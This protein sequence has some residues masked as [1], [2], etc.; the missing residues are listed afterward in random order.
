VIVYNCKRQRTHLQNI[1]KPKIRGE[2]K[3]KNL[4]KKT[5]ALLITLS[6]V[7][8]V[9]TF[10]YWASNVEGTSE[11]ATGTLEVGS[12]DI[13]ETRFELTNDLNSGGL[14]VPVGQAVNSNK[15]ATEAID[16]SFD[17]QWVEDEETS[18][19][20]GVDSVGK[21]VVNHEVTI[22]VNGEALDQEE[23]ANIYALLN[24]EYNEA[25]ASEL[26]LDAAAST[27]AFQI[28]LDEPTDQAEYN[29][30][31]NAEISITFSYEISTEDITTTDVA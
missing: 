6:L 1:K 21:I 26:K 16:L 13:V 27:F 5:I 9:G 12:G 7:L 4:R 8:S 25:N 18:Q 15:G 10:A 3:M 14:L 2:N 23:Y 31:A 24:V 30:I 20:L 19:V 28:T 17:V 22:T 29:L 11:Q